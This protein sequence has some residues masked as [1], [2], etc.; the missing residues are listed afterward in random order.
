MRCLQPFNRALD[1]S[2]TAELHLATRETSAL[3]RLGWNI[4]GETAAAP[5]NHLNVRIRKLSGVGELGVIVYNQHDSTVCFPDLV[6]KPYKTNCLQYCIYLH[7]S[8][9]S[10]F[11]IAHIPQIAFF[12]R[13]QHQGSR[14]LEHIKWCPG[15][16]RG[17]A[18]RWCHEW[19]ILPRI[20]DWYQQLI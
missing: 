7:F 5:S 8:T 13:H 9:F 15:P 1:G 14:G 3:Q 19:I 4:H 10:T 12:H 20:T 11:H 17:V 16:Y 2:S 6:I 18:C